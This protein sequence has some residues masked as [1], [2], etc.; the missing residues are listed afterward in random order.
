MWARNRTNARSGT[1]ATFRSGK[2]LAY[3]VCR[4]Q[5]D[6]LLELKQLLARFGISCFYT[7][8]WG[9]YQ[10]HLDPQRHEWILS[11]GQKLAKGE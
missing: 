4:G 5:D 10:R 6:V 2:V 11:T 7:H 3:V 9:A 8:G 1:P